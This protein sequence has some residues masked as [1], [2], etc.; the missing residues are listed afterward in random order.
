MSC[1]RCVMFMKKR[2]NNYIEDSSNE[3]RSIN[4]VLQHCCN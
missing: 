2:D 4:Y 3:S 1:L